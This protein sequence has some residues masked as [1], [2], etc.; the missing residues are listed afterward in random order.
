MKQGK[1][2]RE[3][4]LEQRARELASATTPVE[5]ELPP[6]YQSTY[7]QDYT[8]KDLPTSDTLGRRVM[9]TQNMEDIK[10]HALGPLGVPLICCR[11]TR[12]PPDPAAARPGRRVWPGGLVLTRGVR[13][14]VDYL[15]SAG[16]WGWLVAQ[17]GRHRQQEFGRGA[18]RGDSRTHV[19]LHRLQAVV[20][21]W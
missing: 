12:L 2:A 19:H 21:V 20:F 5:P 18:R 17:G 14:A 16:C 8:T 6:Q 3:A 13:L 4:L 9:M 7:L 15:A 10:V 1:G 11:P